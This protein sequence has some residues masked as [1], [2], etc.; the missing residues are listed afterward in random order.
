MSTEPPRKAWDL[1]TTVAVG[2]G[3]Q[4]RSAERGRSRNPALRGRSTRSALKPTYPQTSNLALSWSLHTLKLYVETHLAASP[5]RP[6]SHGPVLTREDGT[7]LVEWD[8][9]LFR[10]E[11]QLDWADQKNDIPMRLPRAVGPQGFQA[12]SSQAKREHEAI[13]RLLRPIFS[14]GKSHGLGNSEVI[15][16]KR[17]K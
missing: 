16:R 6:C 17:R 3:P 13:L 9:N 4:P 8:F 12:N 11:G 1:L 10:L 15:R 14:A 7:E 5:R 2:K